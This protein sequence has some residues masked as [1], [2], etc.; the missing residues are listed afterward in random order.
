[1]LDGDG[2]AILDENGD[3]VM[4]D[5]SDESLWGV[6]GWVSAGAAGVAGSAIGGIVQLRNS[7][8]VTDQHSI[9]MKYN[10]SLWAYGKN[11]NG[12]I[13]D[14]TSTSTDIPVRVGASYFILEDYNVTIREGEK[15]QFNVDP[16]ISAF[17]VFNSVEE[18]ASNQDLAWFVW[19]ATE[20]SD[21]TLPVAGTETY[22]TSW[23]ET[24]RVE[25]ETKTAAEAGTKYDQSDKRA[26]I[27]GLKAGTTYVI[28]SVASDP[29]IVG[30]F[31]VQVRPADEVTTQ[32]T[33]G[34]VNI[35]SDDLTV[36]RDF[37]IE[38]LVDVIGQD[39]SMLDELNQPLKTAGVY[40]AATVDGVAG[41]NTQS[42]GLYQGMYDSYI[43]SATYVGVQHNRQDLSSTHGDSV[44]YPSVSSGSN[45]TVALAGDG[46]VW[47]WGAN[48]Y[49]QL[50]I[51][52]VY[53]TTAA[54]Q[55]VIA[56]VRTDDQ[57]MR[58]VRYEYLNNVRK[59]VAAGNFA[60]ALKNDGTV[61][62]WGRND[63]GQLG[64]GTTYS[65]YQRVP[66]ATQMV[67]GGQNTSTYQS[68]YLQ[69]IIDIAAGGADDAH[70]FGYFIQTVYYKRQVPDKENASINVTKYYNLS[71]NAFGVGDNAKNQLS[72]TSTARFNQPISVRVSSGIAAQ[73]AIGTGA[74]GS[75]LIGNGTVMGMG[76]NTYGQI[77]NA[78][79]A[80]NQGIAVMGYRAMGIGSGAGNVYA[81]TY[82]TEQTLN[83]GYVQVANYHH[84]TKN[85]DGTRKVDSD[86]T[87]NVYAWGQ[88]NDT[89]TA[90]DTNGDP[91]TGSTN[92]PARITSH[93][94]GE[95]TQPDRYRGHAVD[96][97]G[98]SVFYTL[99]QE[100]DLV[101][102]GV[103]DYGQLGK[104]SLAEGGPTGEYVLTTDGRQLDRL[105]TT[106]DAE[107]NTVITDRILSVDS[108]TGGYFTTVV[109]GKGDVW[110]FGQN[111][112]G[113]LGSQSLGRPYSTGAKAALEE[114]AMDA[115]TYEAT[116]ILE[117][118]KKEVDATGKDIGPL[119]T[120]FASSFD[121]W[122]NYTVTD[123]DK[124]GSFNLL[125]L[126]SRAMDLRAAAKNG[127]TVE[128]KTL[129]QTQGLTD[130]VVTV[131]SDGVITPV[132]YGETSVL[133]TVTR[134]ADK[135]SRTM[136]FK[137]RVAKPF[138][139]GYY[140]R[141]EILDPETKKV[142]DVEYEL[143]VKRTAEAYA[144]IA[145][146]EDYTL[147]LKADGTVW[148]WGR[149]TW[150]QLGVGYG[151]VGGLEST[152][153]QLK[154][155]KL[156][157]YKKPSN[158]NIAGLADTY[159]PA[160]YQRE[161]AS[162][163]TTSTQRYQALLKYTKYYSENLKI[164]KIA[165]GM[166]FAMALDSEGNVF[167]WGRNNAG[168]I[169]NGSKSN[170]ESIYEQVVPTPTLV[171]SF[172]QLKVAG[173]DDAQVRIVDIFVGTV[174][175][176]ETGESY[177][178]AISDKGDL[179][180]WGTAS[181]SARTQ[182]GSQNGQSLT[183]YYTPVSDVL[184]I[185]APSQGSMTAL[186]QEGQLMSWN[187]V[188]LSS[189]AVTYIESNSDGFLQG[190]YAG[191]RLVGLDAGKGTTYY[192]TAEGELFASGSNTEG[193]M[194]E[195]SAAARPDGYVHITIRDDSGKELEDLRA[196]S[197]G[198]ATMAVMGDGTLYAT[199]LNG[200]GELG[201]D[202]TVNVKEY[203]F[204]MAGQSA[205][206][207]ED[208]TDEQY[209]AKQ[210][211]P[212]QNVVHAD[213]GMGVA[214][215]TR[216]ESDDGAQRGLSAAIVTDGSVYTWGNNDFGQMGNRIIGQ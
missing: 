47:T 67:K 146:G 4:L 121:L 106:T 22:K 196:V 183:P 103:N 180:V 109:D 129:Q 60:Y 202:D 212:I 214:L 204:V 206:R 193:Q 33:G 66:Y 181:N 70:G 172:R 191:Q 169:G 37:K 159:T 207:D 85:L 52:T 16:K 92:I 38:D 154:F 7:I 208:D 69:E 73:V 28:I 123:S 86:V 127:Y 140:D 187:N 120:D 43:D 199:G 79:N 19:D 188:N 115:E 119:V 168:Q 12:R 55:Q 126:G 144:S 34:N 171:E 11:G 90:V 100:G 21:W 197:G 175:T 68:V 182:V 71:D 94:E 213:T 56:Q 35:T 63:A 61:W 128:Y 165:A 185:A 136:Q 72:L 135:A 1:M 40:Q 6:P 155:T 142:V 174:E 3:A 97:G 98:G 48:D 114:F 133:I 189:Q 117:D 147:A 76:D 132:G 170:A 118:D 113:Q 179:F 216:D 36:S 96:V 87:G 200:H 195:A 62:A 166:D 8:S 184:D 131:S 88:L 89:F 25:Y 5:T 139:V 157:G 215:N 32:A 9:V 201:H 176:G 81:I 58:T 2:N 54:P 31:R 95:E 158:V 138:E 39:N 116:L 105:Y 209:L 83:G 78:T 42:G 17:N 156:L 149:N 163:A 192:T 44:G 93:V 14:G 110:G 46:T 24:V 167:A 112:K 210:H 84:T 20:D 141:T 178:A 161:L 205:E 124:N 203:Q 80:G 30:A 64:L 145:V 151:S 15:F 153:Q 13:G 82:L 160:E 53:G 125:K 91:I 59:V 102:S 107:G 130:T 49:G 211:E 45:F 77:G 150:G 99:S 57:S 134:T 173:D 137:V 186:D 18:D 198:S 177:A 10:G 143:K 74:T 194:G 164:V 27:T 50:G 122:M 152:P 162:A 101:L 41:K 108:A 26:T 65:Q 104:G 23:N 148:G 51:G 111:N 190:K 75:I 29:L